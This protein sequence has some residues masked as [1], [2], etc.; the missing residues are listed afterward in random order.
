[1][2]LC[3][4]LLAL[5]GDKGNT[6][7]KY[8]VTP[9]EIAVMMAVHGSDSVFDIEP[10]GEVADRSFREELERLVRAYPGKD[11]D[12]QLHVRRVYPGGSPILHTEIAQLGLPEEAFKTLTRVSAAPPAPA[13]PR[14]SAKAPAPEL[15][16][17]IATAKIDNSA[18]ELFED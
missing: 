4:C 1:M 8:Q 11:E 3:N 5:G 10:T 15:P 17:A 14:K 16:P 7:P 13:K 12:D 9:A 18:D 6:V 2:E